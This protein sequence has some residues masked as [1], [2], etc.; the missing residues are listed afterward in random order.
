MND[1]ISPVNGNEEA[2]PSAIPV[3][4]LPVD[5]AVTAL[6]AELAAARQMADEAQDATL[7]AQAELQNFRR[8]KEREA[9]ERI[10]AA[11]RSLLLALLPVLDDFERAF[12][13]LP[14]SLG[15]ESAA[16][17]EGFALIQRKLQGLLEREGVTPIVAEGEFDP[18][19]H[20]AISAAASDVVQ[21]GHIVEEVQRGYMLGDKVLRPSYVRVAH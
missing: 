7:R 6:V 3:Q 15:Q 17:V 1:S 5:E 8:R 9:D 20:E 16:W 14:A 13:N 10:A 11:N 2:F 4:T 12:T 21:S 19:R 18:T